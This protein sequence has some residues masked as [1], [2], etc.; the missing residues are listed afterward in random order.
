MS[1]MNLGQRRPSLSPRERHKVVA[2]MGH[3]ESRD[4]D[5]GSQPW[6]H[7]DFPM[8]L[9]CEQRMVS[10]PKPWLAALGSPYPSQA[11]PGSSFLRTDSRP[12][13]AQDGFKGA[14]SSSDQKAPEELNRGFSVHPT[15]PLPHPIPPMGGDT[16]SLPPSA[17]LFRSRK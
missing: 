16:Y 8:D 6:D 2:S 10:L 13:R 11:S 15:I 5:S 7:P 12:P 4:L 9:P 3:S 1:C 14:G 17:G